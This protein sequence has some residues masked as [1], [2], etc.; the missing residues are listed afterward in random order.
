[1]ADQFD[2]DLQDP[3]LLDEIRLLTD[4]VAAA[5]ASPVPLS[6]EAVDDLLLVA[7]PP[8]PGA[9]DAAHRVRAPG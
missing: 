3:V 5:T 4:V 2:V 8:A 1:M 6:P 9:T 7:G